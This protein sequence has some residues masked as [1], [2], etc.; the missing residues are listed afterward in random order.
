MAKTET[1]QTPIGVVE[2]QGF[3]DEILQNYTT[4]QNWYKT[5]RRLYLYQRKGLEKSIQKEGV[6]IIATKW[7]EEMNAGLNDVV[8]KYMEDVVTK[9]VRQNED[10]SWS[11]KG[12]AEDDP[13]KD[14]I[15]SSFRIKL[16]Q[17]INNEINNNPF[18]NEPK[19]KYVVA[20]S[21]WEKFLLKE[22]FKKVMDRK[23]VTTLKKSAI[24]SLLKDLKNTGD[25]RSKAAD[26]DTGGASSKQ[27]A[28][29]LLSYRGKMISDSNDVKYI[30]DGQ[31][32]TAMELQTTWNLSD[33]EGIKKVLT[34]KFMESNIE[35]QLQTLKS[36][37][38]PWAQ[39]L[40]ADVY[41][42]NVKLSGQ[43]SLDRSRMVTRAALRRGINKEF[44]E[45]NPPRTWDTQY[46]ALFVAAF[47][48][49]YLINLI[50]PWNIFMS[51]GGAVQW[52]DTYLEEHVFF[53]NIAVRAHT[54]GKASP[55]QKSARVASKSARAASR[56][57]VAYEA[58][59]EI[60]DSDV[61]TYKVS[62]IADFV[63][64]NSFIQKGTSSH[65]WWKE[66][67]RFVSKNAQGIYAAYDNG[68]YRTFSQ[69]ETYGNVEKKI[70]PVLE[71]RS[72][73]TIKK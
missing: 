29:D 54:K 64:N 62:S 56:G 37:N 7:L 14:K 36:S 21:L 18:K 3:K 42:I 68:Q 5:K 55:Q 71:V 59:P 38:N 57:V 45:N 9:G 32:A 26:F 73:I 52:M 2:T 30:G 40:M 70:E 72:V 13:N 16:A 8:R 15:V 66:H 1:D 47:I 58:F 69:E 19:F 27:S 10:G 25:I 24:R 23:P 33:V 22:H 35:Q 49:R 12:F 50:G 61:K 4:A 67:Q 41:G 44:S 65:L 63:N 43:E 11:A 46:T 6:D 60:Y 20:G 51:M 31:N 28:S 17:L 39:Y 53:M 48:S 34:K